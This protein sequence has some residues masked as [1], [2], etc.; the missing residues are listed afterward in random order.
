MRFPHSRRERR[1][2]TVCGRFVSLVRGRWPDMWPSGKEGPPEFEY[3]CEKC[4]A[5]EVQE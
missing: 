2:C 3:T 1:N 4:E 5:K